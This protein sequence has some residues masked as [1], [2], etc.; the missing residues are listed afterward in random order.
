MASIQLSG[1]ASGFDWQSFVDTIMDLERAPINRLTLE[2]SDNQLKNNALTTLDT[3]LKNL[4]SAV[5]GLADV[6][7]F[8]T[9]TATVSG[10][11][12]SWTA[13]ATASSALGAHD[14][15]ILARATAARME[16]AGDRSAGI[17]SSADVS[18]VSLAS[19]GTAVNPSAGFFTI[20]GAQVTVDLGES[21]QD[22]FDRIS[23]A[24]GGV[25]TATYNASTDGIELASASP[26]VLGAA[27]DTSN[28]LSVARLAN[29]GTGAITSSSG[30]GT[31]NTTATLANARLGT[32]ITAV[33]GSGNGSF[34]INGVAIDY[35]VNSDSLAAVIK[36]I[37]Q[38]TAGVTASYDAVND[39]M[40]LSNAK[41]GDLGINVSEASGGFLDAFG[42]TNSATLVNGTNARFTVDGGP[43]IV[44]T[45]NTLTE[46]DH[47]IAGLTL[48]ATTT[49]AGT[50]TVAN[51]AT[52]MRSKIDSFIS[53]YNTVQR[54]IENQSKVSSSNGTVTTSTLSSN[55]EVQSWATAMRRTVFEAVPGL[56]ASMDRLD[57]LG[58]DFV[59]GTNELAVMDSAKLNTA[60]ADNAD[61]VVAFFQQTSTGFASRLETMLTGYLGDDYGTTGQLEAQRTLLTN[62]NTKIDQ[63][64]ADIERRL[65]QRRALLES[66]FIAMET[67]QSKMNQMQTQ[68]TNAFPTGGSSSS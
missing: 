5:D 32:A 45:S 8:A 31:I 63:Q 57:D 48:S 43:E 14:F 41:T 12:S 66:G 52:G 68:L 11:S 49:G 6:T 54:Y 50:V 61:D 21:L 55:R 51:D 13:S 39:R 40:V 19:F 17:A 38:S 27:N 29:N 67:A 25:V 58:I 37:N 20:N 36:R 33:D 9:H 23:T 42:L 15:N 30:L 2:K 56:T 16:G 28:F 1:L 53:A 7:N 18:G 44:S 26:I 10:A 24:T 35:N 60:L 64:I 62:S 59:S 46:S 22:L 65:V 34:S 4:R 3:N 47:G